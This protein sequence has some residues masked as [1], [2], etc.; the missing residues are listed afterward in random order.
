MSFETVKYEQDESVAIITMNRPAALN[1][2]SLQLSRNLRSAVEKAIEDEARAVVLT[3]EGRAFCSGGDLRE[4]LENEKQT[5]R[6]EASLEE[7]LK[8]LHD[9]IRLIRETPIPFVA[10]YKAFARAREQ[11]SR[12][13]ATLFSHP[14]MRVLMRHLCVSVYRLTA[15]EVSFCR[16]PSAKNLR[17]NFL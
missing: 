5:G 12:W 11:T 9:L 1:A 3:G 4:M 15:A 17:R 6:T 8:A 16:E 13:L 10:P 7:P 2:L 14:K